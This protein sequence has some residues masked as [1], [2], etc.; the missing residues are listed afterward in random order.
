M[1]TNTCITV[2]SYIVNLN[3]SKG[4]KKGGVPEVRLVEPQKWRIYR[5][6]I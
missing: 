5:M 1:I 2:V 3:R 4:S 6:M